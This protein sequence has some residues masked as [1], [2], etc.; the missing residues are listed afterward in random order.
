MIKKILIGLFILVVILVAAAVIVPLLIPTDTIKRELQAQVKEATGRDLVIDGDFE[1]KL[2]PEAILRA[3]NVRFQN[4]AGGSRPDMVTLKE[5]RVH[6]AILPLLS[7]TVEVKEFVLDQPDILLE[8]DKNGKANWAFK[9]GGKG[10]EGK[11]KSGG[12]A[13][14]DGDDLKAISLGDVRIVNGR[15]EYRDAKSGSVETVEGLNLTVNLPSLDQPFS[16]EGSAT[17]HKEALDLRIGAKSPRALMSGGKT[18]VELAI[19][20]KPLKLTYGGQVDVGA[21]SVAGKLDLDVP[22]VRNLAAWAGSPIEVNGDDVLNALKISG[23]LAAS[24]AQVSFSGMSLSLDKINAN[25]DLSAA[26]GGA[27][28]SVKGKLTVDALDLNPYLAAF[29]G[30]AEAGGA[31]KPA[32]A[33]GSNEWSD[34]PIDMSAL[35]WVNADLTLAVGSLQAQEIKVGKSQ[36]RVQ[37]AGGKL[38]LNLSEMALYEGN[39]TLQLNVDASGKTPVIKTTFALSGLQAE[40]FLTDAAKLEWLSGTAAMDMSITT[41]GGSQK[42]LANGL[43]GSGK[44]EFLNG[45]VR[46]TNIA[47]L[48]RGVATLKLDPASWEESKTDFAELG[49]TFTIK[50]GVLTNNDMA[51]K[52]QLLRV[53][54]AGT[55]GI[56]PRNIDYKA[57]PK[58]VSSLEGQGGAADIGGL[59]I[60]VHVTGPWDNPQTN[61]ALG[62]DS[63]ADLAKNP[64]ALVSALAGLGAIKDPAA[65]AKQLGGGDAG[66]LKALQGL[67]GSG[68]G[69]SPTD[70]LKALVPGASGGA[71]TGA[72]TGGSPVDALKSLVPGLSGG[73]SS[74]PAPTA[75]ATTAPAPSQPAVPNP[76]DAVKK[77]FGR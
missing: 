77:L 36:V 32:A 28:P 24:A 60:G 31:A 68:G 15:L 73:S 23:Q 62:G 22:S 66:V 41:A 35:R 71:T 8:V 13:G 26:L 45:A 20:G 27:V 51:L 33:A 47:A 69:G 52:S 61:Y 7:S 65:L 38:A 72:T 1:F 74:A 19:N 21:G 4:A 46:G 30:G 49:G 57:Q 14:G 12:G 76:E 48:L 34:E 63:L 17:W 16:A 59:P 58:L 39:G 44:M 11:G 75:P 67:G 5:L 54:G 53:S 6:V 42:A 64:E 43:N 37:L 50:N 25:G 40:P 9:S 10:D 18:D 2:L 29:G 3:G 55:V 56:G 70:A